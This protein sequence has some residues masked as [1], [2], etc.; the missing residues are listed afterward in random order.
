MV[1]MRL[2]IVHFTWW[3]RMI[4]LPVGSGTRGVHHRGRVATCMHHFGSHL[5][6]IVVL[7]LPQQEDVVHGHR[8]EQVQHEPRLQVLL[9]DTLGVQDDFV[10][11]VVED[12]TWVVVAEKGCMMG[13]GCM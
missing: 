2:Q 11:E 8:G 3:L 4:T 12:Y 13:L 10:S 1:L 7:S 9:G 5:D 6:V